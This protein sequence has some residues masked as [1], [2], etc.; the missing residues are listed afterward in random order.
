M[1]VQ[2]SKSFIMSGYAFFNYKTR[3]KTEIR[4]EEIFYP[5]WFS[6]ICD[7]SEIDEVVE[8]ET[9]KCFNKNGWGINFSGWLKVLSDEEI[10]TKC[11]QDWYRD[12]YNKLKITPVKKWKMSKILDTLTGEQFIQLC[13]ENGMNEGI[14]EK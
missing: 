2:V 5:T 9:Q 12:S 14:V 8:K 10:K 7:D 3:F 4:K 13:K 6:V 11:N 1:L